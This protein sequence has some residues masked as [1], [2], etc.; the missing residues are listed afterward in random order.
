MRERFVECGGSGP[1]GVRLRVTEAGEGPL[2]VLLHGFPES[3]YSWRHQLEPLAAAGYRVIAPDQRGYGHSSHPEP[4]EAYSVL[5][6]VGDVVALIADAGAENAVVVGHDWGAIVAWQLAAMRPDLVRA[7]AGLS[8]PPRP[9]GQRPPL[10]AYRALHAGR[11]Y[12]NHIEKP[13]V[14]DAEMARDVRRSLRLAF[15]GLSGENPANDPP[16]PLLVPDGDGL[17]DALGGR[18]VLPSWLSAADL[19]VFAEQFAPET[20]GFTGALNWYRN[21]DTDWPALAAFDGARLRMPALFVAGDRDTVLSGPGSAAYVASLPGRHP[22]M[23]EPVILTGCG[24]WAQQERPA[25]VTA[26]LLAFLG[27]LSPRESPDPAV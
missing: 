13:G 25:E 17:P 7:V 22:G 3:A 20:G 23:R 18:D 11:F 14:A 8:V 16:Q 27:S 10:E 26:E 24:H 15:D 9:R 4:V 6:L 1:H 21:L 2:V 12:M 19:D 5:R